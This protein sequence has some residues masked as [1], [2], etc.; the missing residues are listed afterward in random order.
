[1][2]SQHDLPSDSNPSGLRLVQT[3]AESDSSE[4]LGGGSTERRVSQDRRDRPT[5]GWDSLLGFHRR[6]RGRREGESENIYVDQYDRQDVTLTIAILVLN[7]LDAFFTLRWLD[8]GGAEGN[9]LMAMLIQASDLMFILQKCLVV[10]LWIVILMIHK[11]FRIAR[12][13][14][15]G[16]LV[17][18]A[19]ILVYHFSLQ[20]MGP[21]PSGLPLSGGG[22]R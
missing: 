5:K 3:P 12:V 18:Y 21:P 2:A 15:W 22:F 1:L 7:I 10:G 8:M 4:N 19:C 11:N 14:L 6:Q 17:L 9:P 20:T 16:A 13:G